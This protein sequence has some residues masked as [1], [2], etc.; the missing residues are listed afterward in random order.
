MLKK[1]KC[2]HCARLFQP[3]RTGHR[4]CSDT[5]RKLEFKARKRAEN[6]QKSNRRLG[7]KLTKFSGS[8]F[9]RYLVREIRRAGTVQVLHGHTFDSLNELA[10]LR[11]KCTASSGYEH[12]ETLGAYE[13]SHIHPAGGTRAKNIGLLHPANLVITPKEFNRKH[14]TK[15]PSCGYQGRF[16]QRDVIDAKW[17]VKDGDESIEVLKLARKFIGADFDKWL[18]KHLV[19]YTQKQALVKLLKTAGLPVD[20]LK[21]MPLKALK[22]LAAEEELPYFDIT[23]SP[24]DIRHILSEEM[25]RLNVCTEFI[26]SLD[27]LAEYDW[28]FESPEMEFSGTESKRKVFEKFLIEQ[29]LAAL[30]GQPFTNKWEKKAALSHFKKRKETPYQRDLSTLDDIL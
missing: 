19:T 2:M 26:K 11:R 1:I 22:A 14:S 21:A 24:A 20:I 23:K 25:Q 18:K 3:I 12:G 5:C 7:E 30:H 9:G 6:A 8:T 16:I 29:S 28:S 13:L 15:L 27:L 17:Q 4:F 10:S